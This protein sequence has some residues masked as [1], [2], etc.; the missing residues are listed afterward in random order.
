MRYFRFQEVFFEKMKNIDKRNIFGFVSFRS[1]LIIIKTYLS[2]LLFCCYIRALSRMKG[3]L[4]IAT[5]FNIPVYLHW[6]F[7]LIFLWIIFLGFQVNE[8]LTGIATMSLLYI[9]IFICVVLHEYGHAL[10]ARRYGVGTRDIILSPIGGIARLEKIPEKPSEELKVALAGPAVNVIIAIILTPL[11]Y[12][13]RKDGLDMVFTDELKMMFQLR[14]TAPLV[15]IVNVGLVMFNMVPAFPMD[16]GRVL[17]SLLAMKM[18]RV[19]ATKV[20]YVIAQFCALA[21]FI[22]GLYSGNYIF[23]FIAI[24][25]IFTSRMEW[26]GVQRVGHVAGKTIQELIKP[27]SKKLYRDQTIREAI[28]MSSAAE[29]YFLIFNRNE[30]VIGVLFKEFIDHAKRE[31]DLDAP[32]EKYRSHTW[33]N[34]PALYPLESAIAVF[35]QRGFGIVPVVDKQGELVGQLDIQTIN[36]FI[37]SI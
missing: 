28:N 9:I 35:Q 13:F 11:V 6:S 34:M 24:F 25:V 12:Y 23:C 8:G 20:A 2:V 1:G 7:P 17:R 5:L 26:K 3:T 16:G 36:Q 37:K 19:K 14:Y 10:M 27:I 33:E 15:I 32:V 29:Q 4:K 18:N 31:N 30:K 22:I 21:F